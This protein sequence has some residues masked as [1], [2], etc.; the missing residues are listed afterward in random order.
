MRQAD[1]E[2]MKKELEAAPQKQTGFEA[3]NLSPALAWADNLNN[4]SY[5]QS[6]KPKADDSAALKKAIED[7]I[8]KENQALADDQ[9]KWM[10][11]LRKGDEFDTKMDMKQKFLDL[12]ADRNEL[13]KDKAEVAAAKGPKLPEGAYTA[14]GFSKR[15]MQTEEVF[16]DLLSQ[17]YQ[18]PGY[19]EKFGDV[20]LPNQMMG[21]NYQKYDQAVRNFV[22]ATLRRESGASISDQEFANARKQYIPQ[23]GDKPEVLAQ[24]AA[25]R[26]QV[27]E[28]FKA[29]GQGAFDKIQ[30]VS[31]KKATK[32][33]LGVIDS[34]TVRVRKGNEILEI[35]REDLPSAAKDGY[36]EVK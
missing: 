16:N 12:Y 36:T 31:P 33:G 6:Y 14:A 9:I 19:A 27:F 30:Y 29:E 24:K 21:E 4:T 22:N 25:N 34:P 2:K 20:V 26:R 5:A 8:A 1:I 11:A 35:S 17:G 23:P 28:N 10:D 13:A 32:A 15:L 3:L 7:R 18:G